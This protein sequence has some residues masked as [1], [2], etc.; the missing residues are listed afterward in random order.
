VKGSYEA[1]LAVRLAGAARDSVRLARRHQLPPRRIGDAAV[2]ARLRLT[3]YLRD[4]REAT[5]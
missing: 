4:A 2:E 3:L 5:P 1:D